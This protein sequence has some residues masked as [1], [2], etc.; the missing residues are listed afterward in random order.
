MTRQYEELTAEE[1]LEQMKSGS[2]VVYDV[3]TRRQFEERHIRGARW[4]PVSQ[5]EGHKD[6]LP[7]D[8]SIVVYCSNV[9]CTASHLAAV[10]LSELGFRVYR[11]TGGLE[12]W[13]SKGYPTE[14]SG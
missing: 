2:V 7:R 12:E 6:D 5:I 8:K 4:L 3:R 11:F 1:L 9:R 14:G 10:K 13:V